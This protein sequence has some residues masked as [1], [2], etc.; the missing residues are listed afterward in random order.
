MAICAAITLAACAREEPAPPPIEPVDPVPITTGAPTLLPHERLQYDLMTPAQQAIVDR[1]L[2]SGATLASAIQD[3]AFGTPPTVTTGAPA[4]SMPGS[5]PISSVSIT[6]NENELV[7]AFNT[8]AGIELTSADVGACAIR[9]GFP[10]PLTVATA[11][12]ETTTRYTLM[13][14]ATVPSMSVEATELCIREKVAP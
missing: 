5:V 10:K 1:Y 8:D 7:V 11:Q 9:S 6:D 14:P 13:V 3:E 2:A 4:A 12:E